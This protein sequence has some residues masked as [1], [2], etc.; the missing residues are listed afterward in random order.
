LALLA[1]LFASSALA[2]PLDVPVATTF[3]NAGL[4][5]SQSVRPSG[6]MFAYGVEVSVHHFLDE[7]YNAGVGLFGQWQGTNADHSRYC[8]GV[9]GTYKFLG[10]ELGAAYENPSQ[11][12]AGTTSLHVAPFISAAGFATLAVRVGIPLSRPSGPM[13][14]HGMD[15]GLVVSLKY[16]LPLNGY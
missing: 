4:L 3:L 5:L 11:D 2:D 1:G 8:G 10:L 14:G 12:F 6:G 13:P 9:Q 15:L 16:P 7:D